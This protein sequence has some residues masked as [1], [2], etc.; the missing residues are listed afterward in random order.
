MPDRPAA[1][2]PTNETA[3]RE[4]ALLDALREIVATCDLWLSHDMW[5]DETTKQI[6][7]VAADARAKVIRNYALGGLGSAL[8]LNP[9]REGDGASGKGG[10]PGVG[11]SDSQ[12]QDSVEASGLPDDV[13]RALHRL[14]D[15]Y[16]SDG[17][18]SLDT[19]IAADA[20]E[21]WLAESEHA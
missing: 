2:A 17:P 6:A 11:P 12:P 8:P 3:S 1:G 19:A 18:K 20:L 9:E 21:T 4:E 13:R 15:A 16:Y 10:R 14:L 7:Q 5:P